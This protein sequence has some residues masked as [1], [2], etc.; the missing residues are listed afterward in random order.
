[1][2]LAKI[3]ENLHRYYQV[4]NNNWPYT[5][6]YLVEQNILGQIDNP[7]WQ[8]LM[9]IID[10]IYYNYQN[11]FAYFQVASSDEFFIPDD[12]TLFWN[13]AHY[14][15]NKIFRVIPKSEHEM[16]GRIGSV[17]QE[18]V[19]FTHFVFTGNQ[20]KAFPDLTF[21]DGWITTEVPTK[22]I[23]LS[24]VENIKKI[25][26]FRYST[27]NQNMRDFRVQRLQNLPNCNQTRFLSEDFQLQLK[28]F[29]TCEVNFDFSGCE[30]FQLLEQ[31][32]KKFVFNLGDVRNL[33]SKIRFNGIFVEFV[34]DFDLK[35]TTPVF[36]FPEFLPGSGCSGA[37]CQGC[38]V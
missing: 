27:K 11:K 36:V 5:F 15:K 30:N 14:M 31:D 37:S 20:N 10:P 3:T 12:I 32:S 23:T 25:T 9:E 22:I 7:P 16:V 28:K 4:Y 33:E 13:Q 8:K 24:D 26:I 17:E 29:T 34:V 18:M 19:K 1:M 21:E 38:L 2:S 6:N 35:L